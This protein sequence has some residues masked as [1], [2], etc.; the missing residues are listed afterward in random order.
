MRIEIKVVDDKENVL[1][2]AYSLF[3]QIHFPC[4]VTTV[5]DGIHV[6]ISDDKGNTYVLEDVEPQ[7]TS[8]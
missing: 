1:C 3:T 6:T 2:Q 7:R 8:D 5:L 4:C